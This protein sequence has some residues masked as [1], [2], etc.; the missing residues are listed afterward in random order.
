MLTMDPALEE[1]ARLK[2]QDMAQ[3]N[4]FAHESPAYGTASEML[5]DAGYSYNGVGENIAHYG[6]VYKAHEALM[7]SPGHAANILSNAWTKVGVGVA[8]DSR[9]YPLVTQLFAF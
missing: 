7:S 3:N 5:T 2:S 6:D 4:Y 1:L 9:G 8:L